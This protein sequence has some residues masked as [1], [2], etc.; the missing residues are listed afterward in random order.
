MNIRTLQKQGF[1]IR[2]KWRFTPFNIIVFLVLVLYC[3]ILFGLFIWAISASLKTSDQFFTDALGFAPGFAIGNYELAIRYFTVNVTTANG[4]Y[5]YDFWSQ[6]LNSLLYA[7][8]CALFQ[9]FCTSLVAYLTSK[10]KCKFSSLLHGLVIVTLALPI[11]GNMA[12]MLQVTQA[13]GTYDTLIGMWIMKFG[14]NNM[15]YLIFYA[16]FS[17]ISW[18]YAEAAFVDGA[19]HYTVY[20]RI[21]FP[22]MLPLMGTV[23]LMFFIQ[24]WNDYQTPM[25]YLPSQP[26]IAYGLY[27]FMWS[28][29]TEISF[30]PI[31]IA[32]GV[33]V[34]LPVFIVFMI[35]RE[36]LMGNLTAGGIKE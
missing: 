1:R 3:A 20:F 17:R 30:A 25:V 9:V 22:V 34:F 26:T 19:S 16:A 29:E 4:I 15:Y 33:L 18:E 13:M 14:F 31:K 23:F 32:G 12:S 27:R 2:R 8:G 28:N 21:M 5:G 11:V 35:F 7:G 10:Y 36:K 24:Y 6:L